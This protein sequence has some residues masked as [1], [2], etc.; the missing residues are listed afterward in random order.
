[1]EGAFHNKLGS[2]CFEMLPCKYS[3]FDFTEKQF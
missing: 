1:M 2:S 3:K